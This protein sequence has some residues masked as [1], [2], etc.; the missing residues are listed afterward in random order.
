MTDETKEPG[1]GDGKPQESTISPEDAQNIIEEMEKEELEMTANGE[2][3]RLIAGSY[4]FNVEASIIATEEGHDNEPLSTVQR[5]GIVER[6]E[7]LRLFIDLLKGKPIEESL[8]GRRENVY[9]HLISE[10][11]NVGFALADYKSGESKDSRGDSLL[12]NLGSIVGGV[13]AEYEQRIEGLINNEK[14]TRYNSARERALER[15]RKLDEELR[16]K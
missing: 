2:L 3:L 1:A 7:D 16:R 9:W 13:E 4:L 6:E 14:I 15:A 8:V 5:K 12:R 10:V 11:R